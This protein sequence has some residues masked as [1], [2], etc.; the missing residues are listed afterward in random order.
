M[1]THFDWRYAD[2]DLLASIAHAHALQKAGLLTADETATMVGALGDL[3]AGVESGDVVPA[4]SDEDVHGALERLLIDRIGP[5]IGELFRAGR[6]RNDQIATLPRMYLRRE[7]RAISGLVLDLSEALLEQA[8]RHISAPMPGRTHFQHASGD[9]RAFVAGARVAAFARRRTPEG[10]GYAG[11]VV[12]VRRRRLGRLHARS[13]PGGR[14][15]GVGLCR[16]RRK[17]D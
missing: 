1:S 16:P 3:R 7:A 4:A 10:L 9:A 13:G 17:L 11:I 15:I 5:E 8:D 12:A 6:S 2:D 14:G